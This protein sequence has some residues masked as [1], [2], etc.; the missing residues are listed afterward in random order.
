MKK[1]FTNILTILAIA[2]LSVISFGFFAKYEINQAVEKTIG[3]NLGASVS[4]TAVSDTIN[5]FRLNV[6]SSLANLN[7]A[8]P[9]QIVDTTSSPT[10]GGLTLTGK[11][12]VAKFASGILG[13]ATSGTDYEVPLTASSGLTRVSNAFRLDMAGGTCGVAS[14]ISS[15]SATGTII[16]TE[17]TSTTTLSVSTLTVSATSTFNGGNTFSATSTFTGNIIS[18]NFKQQQIFTASTTWTVPT[19]ITT[20]YVSLIGSGGGGGGSCEQVDVGGSNNIGASGASGGSGG[21][22]FDMATTTTS[23]QIITIVIGDAG[24]GGAG[25]ATTPSAGTSGASSSAAGFVVSGGGGGQGT[26]SSCGT[27]ALPTVAVAGLAPIVGFGVAGLPGTSSQLGDG[28]ATV[29]ANS[30]PHIGGFGAVS[31]VGTGV[32]SLGS[33]GIGGSGAGYNSQ[34]GGNY[35]NGGVGTNGLAIIKW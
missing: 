28:I 12:G 5:Q 2:V 21:S 30:A 14:H 6:N 24:T 16:C 25:S 35:Y 3:V 19:G 7:A 32:T 23:G 29:G 15:L 18:S 22:A 4:S 11:S 31:I 1:G 34:V 27:N 17:D 9:T 13:T 8:L 10:F 26:V 20:I 33:H